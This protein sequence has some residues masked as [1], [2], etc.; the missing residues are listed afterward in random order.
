[1]ITTPTIL[2]LD[3]SS[4]TIGY[5][6][7]DG[8][9]FAFGEVAL[10]GSDIA[11]R[12]RQAHAHLN[13]L[14]HTMCAIDLIAIE[15]PGSMFKKALIPQCRVSGALMAAAALKGFLVVEVSPA[16]AKKALAGTGNAD[17]LAMQQ[18]AF[19]RFG[20]HGEHASDALGVALASVGMVTVERRAA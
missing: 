15:A 18:A 11:D 12:C 17:K 9:V 5:C 19:R 16:Q 13:L 4:T 6:V 7:F 3:A 20:V 2:A 8:A 1:M 14:L 10:S